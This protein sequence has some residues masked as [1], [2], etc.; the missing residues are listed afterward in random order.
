MEVFNNLQTRCLASRGSR[1]VPDCQG[2]EERLREVCLH[3]RVHQGPG[4]Q[5]RFARDLSNPPSGDRRGK[6][7]LL[8]LQDQFRRAQDIA[9]LPYECL[10]SSRLTMSM[11]VEWQLTVRVSRGRS[12]A[13]NKRA[14]TEKTEGR[15]NGFVHC[16]C[17]YWNFDARC[18]CS[19]RTLVPPSLFPPHP[20]LPRND[21]TTN[22]PPSPSPPC[23]DLPRPTPNR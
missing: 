11:R 10:E 16:D 4:R 9:C 21:H 19:L 17:E 7:S 13:V 3:V 18:P 1:T 2:C 5:S 14:G 6:G 22:V 8:R 20:S 15:A 12:D 23:H